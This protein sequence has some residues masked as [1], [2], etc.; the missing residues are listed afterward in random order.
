MTSSVSHRTELPFAAWRNQVTGTARQ[1]FDSYP[2][3]A[4]D[5]QAGPAY[6]E[7]NLLSRKVFWNRL[8]AVIDWI[9]PSGASCVDFGCG[10]GLLLPLLSG[11]YEQVA[12]IEL[13]HELPERFLAQWRKGSDQPLHNVQIHR[14]LETT[15]LAPASVDLILALDVL[16][17]VDDL[18]SLAQQLV[19]LLKPT[20]RLIISGPTENLAY[21]IGRRIVGFSGDYH[22]RNVQDIRQVVSRH[23]RVEQVRKIG[24]GVPLFH[25]LEYR[26]FADEAINHNSQT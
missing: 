21:R 13:V 20:G 5:E 23:A 12:G 4:L 15:G 18:D 1:V 9:P 11:R 2:T 19:S 26:P 8:R 16:E 14:S 7:G 10:F 24:F 25:L 22:V 3:H 6:L 17:H